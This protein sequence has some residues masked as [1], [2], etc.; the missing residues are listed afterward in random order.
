MSNDIPDGFMVKGKASGGDVGDFSTFDLKVKKLVKPK[1]GNSQDQGLA[2]WQLSFILCY[3][4]DLASS[5]RR[6][7]T[8]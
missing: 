7:V 3:E 2:S 6:M 8:A 1:F 4:P 5:T